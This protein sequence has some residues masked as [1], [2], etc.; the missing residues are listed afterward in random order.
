MAIRPG[1]DTCESAVVIVAHPDDEILWCGGLILQNPDWDWTVLS[2]CR[3]RDRDRRPKFLSV[4]EHLQAQ[5]LISDLDDGSPLKAIDASR[6]IGGRIRQQVGDREWDL[7]VTH[8]ENGEYG[9][10]RHR[11]V[12]AEVLRLAGAGALRC[13]ELWSFA[14]VCDP[15]TGHCMARRDA[16]LRIALTDGQ[17]AEKRRIVH[18]MYGYAWDSFEVKACVS[19]EGF[20]RHGPGQEGTRP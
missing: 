6:E 2:L 13:G 3:S 20:R 18:E 14:S 9:H 1:L 15:Q 17:L 10:L 7:C 8:G 19:P 12:H 16:D 5:G 11:Q 4:C